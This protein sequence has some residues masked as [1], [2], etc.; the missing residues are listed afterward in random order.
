MALSTKNVIEIL[1]QLKKDYHTN[2]KYSSFESILNEELSNADKFVKRLSMCK[3]CERHQQNRPQHLQQWL[4]P[5][6]SNTQLNKDDNDC[7]CQCRHY[8]RHICRACYQ[9]KSKKS[10]PDVSL[11]KVSCFRSQCEF[12]CNCQGK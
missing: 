5:E 1:D 11:S 9:E 2:N 12:R 7:K 3:C 10:K 8:S 6:F 4:E